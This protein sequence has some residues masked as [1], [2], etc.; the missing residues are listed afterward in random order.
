MESTS[1]LPGPTCAARSLRRLAAVIVLGA[2]WQA[3]A[4][5]HAAAQPWSVPLR[6]Q[7]ELADDPLQAGFQLQPGLARQ[8][9]PVTV[10]VPLADTLGVGDV[11]EL[12]LS[13]ATIGQFRVLSR[14]PSGNVQWVLVDTQTDLAAGAQS[15]AIALV[16]G[17]GSFGGANLATDQGTTILVDTGAAR[18]TIRKQGFNLLDRAVVG[19]TEL[20]APGTSPGVELVGSDGT[21]YNAGNDPAVAVEI[22]ENGPARAV[23]RA[24]GVHRSAAGARNLEFTARLTFYRGK[25]RVRVVYT[26]RNASLAQV[27]NQPFQSLELVLQTALASSAFRV[28]THT[29][30]STGNLAPA[31]TLRLFLGENAFPNF[32]DYDFTDFD[33]QGNEITTKWPTAIRGYTLRRN[34][35]TIASGTRTQFFDLAYARASTALGAVTFGTRF[36]AGW[37]PQGLGID[38]NGRIRIGLF[39]PGN[40]RSYHA[41]FAG[42]VSR[43]VLLDFAAGT[44]ADSARDAMYRFQYPLLGKAADVDQ[45]WESGALWEP[46]L[47]LPE[48]VA[49]Y[50][51][52]GW[53]TQE[54]LDRRP[55]FNLYRHYY[56]GTGGGDNQYDFT[57]V[58]LHNFLR[59]DEPFA[60]GWYLEAEQ[61]IAYNADLS[62]YHS[63]DFAGSADSAPRF[64]DLPNIQFV[65]SAKATFEGEHRHAY[66]IPLLYY[67]TGDERL[68]ESYADWGDWMHHFNAE[69]F[70]DYERGLVWNLY[71][72]VDLYRF[73]GNAAHRDLAW[74]FFADEVLPPA[75]AG[76]APGTDW[77]R[78]FFAARWVTNNPDPVQGRIIT[79]FVYSA[80]FP[81][82]YA[83]LHDYG[84]LPPLD[85]DRVRDVLEGITRFVSWEHWY[86]YPDGGGNLTVGNYGLPYAQSLD[87]P[88]NPPD[89]RLEPNWWSGFKEGWNTFFYGYLM[90][91][92]PE[93][94]RRGELLQRAAAANPEGWSWFQDWPDRQRLQR[95]LDAPASFPVW[96][97]L[98]LTVESLG[99]GSYR[100][101]W[102]VPPGTTG[103]WIKRA[104]RN[105][106]PWLGF[107]RVTR[108]Y[109][110]DPASNVPFFAAQNLPDEPAPAAPGTVQTWTVTGLPAGTRFAARYLGGPVAG[111]LPFGDGFESGGTSAWSASTP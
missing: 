57:K 46:V 59:R 72:L 27:A 33:G 64:E 28:A 5:C 108:Q 18:F 111:G 16:P 78:G 39:P 17:G 66:G 60:A 79:S 82:A 95:L 32:R 102:T 12:G 101:S 65:P 103:Y 68:R 3:F 7:E 67:L 86:E 25:S 34:A 31:D 73:T 104:D 43:E 85:R 20:V 23:V 30:D 10:G 109:A 58:G 91:G 50:Q 71:N 110:I 90:T 37:W 15:T 74:Q 76:S 96:R 70:N 61:R 63:D 81:R 41:R 13:G 26:M 47:A 88:R 93:L 56:W 4:A 53:P 48:E 1:V 19:G 105:I 55:S 9:E 83:Y 62:V 44:P 107:D 40:D 51:A 100:L 11:D 21:V 45:Y 69:G 42:H 80:M 98:P 35:T 8:G 106:V 92:D 22:E 84:D 52:H 54:L 14:W 38:G 87:V 99:G 75:V 97:D 24:R 29:G 94:L 49:A 36:A 6:V 89:A 2:G 77:Q